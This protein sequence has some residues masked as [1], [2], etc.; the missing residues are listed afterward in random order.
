MVHDGSI[1]RKN[2][3]RLD[4]LVLGEMRGRR[5]RTDSQHAVGFDLIGFV[6]H[7]QDQIGRPILVPAAG[8]KSRR[9]RQ[10]FQIALR[11][12]GCH[13]G[14][15][16]PLLVVRQ[17][18]VVGKMAV[19]RIGVPRRHA[20]LIDDFGDHFG[21][22]GRVLIAGER[23]R[24]DVAR[25]MAFDAAFVEEP[26]DLVGIRDVGVRLAARAPGR[27]GSRPAAC[28]QP[29]RFAPRA[30]RRRV[31]EFIVLRPSCGQSRRR[32]GRRSALDSGRRGPRRA[33]RLRASASRQIVRR[34]CFW[35]RAATGKCDSRV[36]RVGGQ[37]GQRVL[38]VRID[39][40]ERDAFACEWVA[41]RPAAARTVWP[42]GIP[43]R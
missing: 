41:S 12:T 34:R 3:R 23:E 19:L 26:R 28:G 27:S 18:A 22:G 38:H 13:P 30:A 24:G 39:R 10:F 40:Q 42:A 25:V 37:L 32:I 33:R 4:P 15:D 6:A 17:P 11:R 8:G 5:G 9:R 29:R 2:L 14:V 31:F 1:A 16:Q 21:P 35:R 43:Y 7:R 36:P 20:A